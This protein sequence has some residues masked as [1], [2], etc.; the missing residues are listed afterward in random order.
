M[1][2]SCSNNDI[3]TSTVISSA[4]AA[5]FINGPDTKSPAI[6]AMEK[7]EALLG[8]IANT[9]NINAV[10][11]AG[12]SLLHLSAIKGDL[13]AARLLLN[14]G[15]NP[16]AK[17]SLGKTAL[18]A[19]YAKTDSLAHARVAEQVIL[20]G[21]SSSNSLFS[22]FPLAVKSSNANIRL[23]DGLAPLHFASR[24]GHTGIMQL[25]LEKDA[26]PAAKSSS[27]AEPLHEA[28]RYGKIDAARILLSSGANINAR[29]A[30]GNTVLHLIMPKVVRQEG[31]DFLLQNGADP[32]AKDDYG[33]TALHIALSLNL[34]LAFTDSLLQHGA[35]LSARNT[36]GKTPLHTAVEKNRGPYIQSLLDKGADI[37]ASD[38]EGKTPFGLAFFANEDILASLLTSKTVLL[39]DNGGNS[40]LHLTAA[41]NTP[42]RIIN[43]ILDKKADI[44]KRNKSGDTALHI[45]IRKDYQELGELLISRNADIFVTNAEGQSPL[46][47][48]AHLEP[49]R[50]WVLNPI[51]IEARDSLGNSVLHF[52]AVWKLD[53][54]I[55]S[56]VEGGVK[57]DARNGTGETPLFF[58]VKANSPSTVQALVAAGAS[59]IVRDSRGN[60]ALHAAIRWNAEKSAQMLIDGG[61]DVNARNLAGKTPLHDAVRLGMA[62]LET[63]LINKGASL[64]SRDLEGATPLMEAVSSGLASTLERLLER[65]ADPIARN[66]IGNTPLHI[67]VMM[68]RNDIASLLLARGASIHA[69]NAEGQTPL[70]LALHRGSRLSTTLLTKDRIDLVDDEGRS[71]LFIGLSEGASVAT[72]K[73]IIDL[74][75]QVASR[76]AEGRTPLRFAIQA[77]KYEEARLL[78][79]AGSDVFISG[80]DGESAASLALQGG[81]EAIKA[82]F[83][84]SAIKNKDTVGNTILHIAAF[85]SKPEMVQL[86]LDLGAIKN[87]KNLALETPADIARRWNKGENEKLLR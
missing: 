66:S 44:N 14:K 7:S 46:Y 30:K 75:G 13:G 74:G 8:S 54:L 67:A 49:Y 60:T 65:G 39:S 19:C 1:W 4:G 15:A 35:D 40:P 23:E 69:R 37:F 78:V 62:N 70:R 31:L 55:P 53:T 43:L 68:E 59:T 47:L 11:D 16:K 36:A 29:D 27:G 42:L 2:I 10:D 9:K 85:R 52:A 50:E 71:A 58:A 5:L 48:A 81:K 25:L 33:D 64:E 3:P 82:L 28:I 73:A 56:I 22:Y 87:A 20:A 26:D 38:K 6:H 45:T 51:S 21:A 79:A 41:A 34:G 80:D 24:E 86:L 18:D 12:R 61:A 72:I 77:G 17:D 84:G 83:D 76:D 57:V 63:K 32:N